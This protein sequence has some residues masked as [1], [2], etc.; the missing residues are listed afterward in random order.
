MCK[1]VMFRRVGWEPAARSVWVYMLTWTLFAL[2]PAQAAGQVEGLRPSELALEAIVDRHEEVFAG[3][4]VK[5]DL[6]RLGGIEVETGLARRL[7]FERA[8]QDEVVVC[9]ADPARAIECGLEATDFLIILGE[10]RVER[11]RTTV[12]V[13]VLYDVEGEVPVPPVARAVWDVILVRSDDGA[14]SVVEIVNVLQT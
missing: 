14:W 3:G 1:L 5:V 8:A 12:R 13:E 9:P 2:A 4:V 6:H 11:P 7:G 10:V